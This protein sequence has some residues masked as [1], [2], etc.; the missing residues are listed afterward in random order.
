M[1][2]DTR[3]CGDRYKGPSWELSEY[4]YIKRR[5]P[6]V[7]TYRRHIRTNVIIITIITFLTVGIYC[8]TEEDISN[9]HTWDI[10]TN[11][12]T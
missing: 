7:G 5:A 6:S 3:V 12:H 2:Q 1:T 4:H 8:S 10:A 11:C 9:I